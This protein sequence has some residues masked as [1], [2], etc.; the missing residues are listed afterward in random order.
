MEPHKKLSL[1]RLKFFLFL[2]VALKVLYPSNY[3]LSL[4]SEFWTERFQIFQYLMKLDSFGGATNSLSRPTWGR[5]PQRD[6][7]KSLHRLVVLTCH[8][9]LPPDRH[10]AIEAALTAVTRGYHDHGVLLWVPAGAR[11]NLGE[12]SARAQSHLAGRGCVHNMDLNRKDYLPVWTRNRNFLQKCNHSKLHSPT[13]FINPMILCVV[14]DS[15]WFL[16]IL[17]VYHINMS[18]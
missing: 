1:A 4:T 16:L 15:G 8:L 7:K 17:I 12:Y 5:K 11:E 18:C 9:F 6:K 13:L 14:S 3:F 10:A 2:N